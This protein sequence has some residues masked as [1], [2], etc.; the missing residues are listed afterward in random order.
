MRHY[1]VTRLAAFG[2][3]LGFSN[4]VAAAGTCYALDSSFT[5]LGSY[6]Y[7]SVGY[8]TD[9]CK[10][11]GYPYAATT[12]GDTCLCSNS[13]PTTNS[14]SSSSCSE[15]CSGYPSDNCGAAN[16]M[17][18]FATGASGTTGSA[19][20]T[21]TAATTATG[22]TTKQSATPTVTTPTVIYITTQG[23][24]QQ[25]TTII[26][27]VTPSAQSTGAARASGSSNSSS[28]QQGSSDSGGGGG[29]GGGAIAGIIIGVLV[30]LAAGGALA[31][32]FWRRRHDNDDDSESGRAFAEKSRNG[33]GTASAL[34]AAGVGGASRFGKG[35]AGVTTDA[36]ELRPP[37]AFDQRLDLG[38]VGRRNSSESLADNYDY[39]RKILRV[40]NS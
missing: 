19:A 16:Y 1:S 14:A 39:S 29:I 4:V 7:Q 21:G 3:A 18:F 22:A 31:Y 9:S 17:Y 40:V 6:T 2:L 27:T 32:F 5:S 13:Q 28:S 35:G 8:C 23:P 20:T 11:A 33:S 37:P 30:L 25:A 12:N 26:K 24:Q 15:K 10:A 36:S 34:G 38:M